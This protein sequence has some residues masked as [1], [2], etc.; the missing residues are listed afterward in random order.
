ML[1]CVN[2]VCVGQP[3]SPGLSFY[4]EHQGESWRHGRPRAQ[5]LG[6]LFF[7]LL[8]GAFFFL[9][10]LSIARSSQLEEHMYKSYTKRRI[11]QVG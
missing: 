9:E 10:F 4:K 8:T 11:H 1:Q 7:L 6:S 5:P 2:S 3:L